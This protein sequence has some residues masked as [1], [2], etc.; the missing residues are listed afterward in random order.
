MFLIGAVPLNDSFQQEPD[1]H[2]SST[3]LYQEVYVACYVGVPL[4]LLVMH[5]SFIDKKIEANYK[6][7][8]GNLAICDI[9]FL[10]GLLISNL[11]NVYIVSNNMNYTP[12]SCT[13]YRIWMQAFAVCMLNSL[14]II[15]INRY[16][17]LV[18]QKPGLFTNKLIFIICLLV[19]WP[20][21][22]VV[23]TLAFPMYMVKDIFCGYNYWFP[24]IREFLLVPLAPLSIAAVFCTCRTYFFLAKHLK[25]V[26]I[27]VEQSKLKDEKS[28][29]IAMTLGGILPLLSCGPT[30]VMAVFGAL[31]DDWTEMLQSWHFAGITIDAPFLNISMSLLQFNPVFDALLTLF[32]VRQYR[33]VVVGWCRRILHF[34]SNR[35]SAEPK[36]SSSNAVHTFHQS[37]TRV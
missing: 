18:K 15:S 22:Y 8:L 20:V 35:V 4:N 26:S 1:K 12:F 13:L 5:L 7:F 2:Y 27:L 36:L 28:L 25:T 30:V 24:F 31:F 17:T 9:L 33:R 23:L 21:F 14:P 3:W 34:R 6:Y 11:V 19:Y 37:S 32:C 29:L 10:I 16:I